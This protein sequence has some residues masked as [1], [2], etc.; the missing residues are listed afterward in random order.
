[1]NKANKNEGV[2]LGKYSPSEKTSDGDL[3]EVRN[4]SEFYRQIVNLSCQH[5]NIRRILNAE[6]LLVF[7]G[8]LD[9][10]AVLCPDFYMQ[11]ELSPAV[12]F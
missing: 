9:D 2:I 1:M 5:P 11:L 4:K 3:N 6:Q 12:S 7:L 10:L 8:R